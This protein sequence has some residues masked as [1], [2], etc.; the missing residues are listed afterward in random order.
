[1]ETLLERFER[2]MSRVCLGGVQE[3]GMACVEFGISDTPY[4]LAF[5]FPC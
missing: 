4:L 1:M 3:N 2:R 5:L